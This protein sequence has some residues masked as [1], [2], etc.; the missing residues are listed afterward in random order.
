MSQKIDVGTLGHFPWWR[1]EQ[2]RRS[3]VVVYECRIKPA[4]GL[5]VVV[6]VRASPGDAVRFALHRAFTA[7]A[8]KALT[9]Q[10]IPPACARSK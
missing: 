1:L 9:S 3:G 5:D 7:R 2:V 10:P 8:D 4:K 6:A